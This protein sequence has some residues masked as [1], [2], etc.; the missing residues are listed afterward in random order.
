M[1]NEA[2]HLLPSLHLRRDDVLYASAGVRPLTYDAEM[3]TG[4]RSRDIHDLSK[5][6]LPNM[7]ALTAGPLLTYRSAGDDLVEAVHT[8]ISPSG[9]RKEIS[10]EMRRDFSDDNAPPLNIGGAS[11]ARAALRYSA[12]HEHVT[13]LVDLVFRK[14]DA[15]WS[16]D[17]AASAV[18]EVA[19]SIAEIMGWDDAW[20][21]AEVASYKEYLRDQHA[22]R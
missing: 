16:K 12:T 8:R 14:F 6:G 3:P 18:R 4:K 17:M 15:G 21:E 11:I 10:Y 19:A 5:E 9:P 22:F 1:L 20:I 2:N 13:N 7:F